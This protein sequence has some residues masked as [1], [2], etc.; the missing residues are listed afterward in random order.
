MSSRELDLYTQATD[1]AQRPVGRQR[2]RPETLAVRWGAVHGR[3]IALFEARGLNHTWW[4][5]GPS[6]G[7]FADYIHYF[8]PLLGPNPANRQE[9]RIENLITSPSR[10]TLHVSR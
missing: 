10:F 8:N 4:L 1:G 7:R 9:L 2:I 3:Q 5:W 6:D